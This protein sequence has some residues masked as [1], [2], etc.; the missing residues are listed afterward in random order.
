MAV[1]VTVPGQKF[2]IRFLFV[3]VINFSVSSLAFWFNI[4]FWKPCF[5]TSGKT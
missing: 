4:S 1:G 5:F 2:L 3:D